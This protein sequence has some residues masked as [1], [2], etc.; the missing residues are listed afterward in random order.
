MVL[1]PSSRFRWV[2]CQLETLRHCLV[3]NVQRTLGE[4]P[5]TLD[6]TYERIL[7]EIPSQNAGDTHRLLQCLTVAVR[8]LRVEELAEVLAVDVITGRTPMLNVD[9]RWEDQKQ[10]ILLACSSLV[11]VVDDDGS[12]FVQFSH[13]SVKEFLTSDRFAASKGDVSRYIIWP[14]PAHIVMAQACLAVLLRLDYHIDKESVKNFPLADYAASHVGDHVGFGNVISRVRD[15]VDCLIDVEKPHFHAWLWVRGKI[16][17]WM[18][19]QI[20][21]SQDRSDI[22]PLY[23]VVQLGCY[24]MVQHVILKRPQDVNASLDPYGTS[25]H[26]ALHNERRGLT[27]TI[28]TL[29]RRDTSGPQ[30]PHS[31]AYGVEEGIP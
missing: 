1:I 26:P 29:C 16:P 7:R 8:P 21:K 18:W 31:T 27:A 20:P 17:T 5:Q 19:P 28:W 25:L 3:R 12:R 11:V 30:R 13:F 14:E 23:H 2:Y 15:A 22:V 10:A 24:G 6:D 9:S 4:L